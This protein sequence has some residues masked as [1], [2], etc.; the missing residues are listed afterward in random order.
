MV[1]TARRTLIP[2]LIVLALA[3]CASPP[4]QAAAPG[5]RTTLR[6]ENRNFSDMV[7]Y[8]ITSVGQ[9]IR[10]GQVTGNTTSV[11]EIPAYLVG[12]A[13]TLRFLADPIGSRV[14]P[15]SEQIAVEPG[16]EVTVTI[17]PSF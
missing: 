15:V 5:T 13:Q 3:A 9:R 11:M 1:R 12:G 4:R 10:L 6:V 17:P 7:I 8:V 16:E 2:L 14:S